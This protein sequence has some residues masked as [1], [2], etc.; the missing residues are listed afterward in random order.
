LP[1]SVCSRPPATSAR[2]GGARRTPRRGAVVPIGGAQAIGRFL[3]LFGPQGA[4]RQAGWSRRR[5]GSRPSAPAAGPC[6]RSRVT[7]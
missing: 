2:S 1:S 7:R 4:G 5:A 6:A 3:T